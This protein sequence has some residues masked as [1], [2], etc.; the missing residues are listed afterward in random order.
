MVL[1]KLIENQFETGHNYLKSFINSVYEELVALYIEYE[2][3]ED[4][5][6]SYCC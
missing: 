4:D 5:E 1:K 2:R 6:V 3:V